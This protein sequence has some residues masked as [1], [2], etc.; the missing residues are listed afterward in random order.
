[1]KNKLMTAAVVAALSSAACIPVASAQGTAELEQLKA[2]LQALQAKVEEMEKQ[3]K[4]QTEAQERATDMIAQQRTNVGE[5]V[6]R[7]QWKGDLR[8]RNE[9]ID[10]EGTAQK[11]NRD[12][13]RLRGGF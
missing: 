6:S 7:F 10:Q 9:T 1:M 5:W 4:A 12:R 2:Q 8:Y 11:R 3:Q 13:I